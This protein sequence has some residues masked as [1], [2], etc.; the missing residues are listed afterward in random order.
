METPTN[1]ANK[2]KAEETPIVT[3]QAPQVILSTPFT[4]IF[5]STAMTTPGSIDPTTDIPRIIVSPNALPMEL[6]SDVLGTIHQMIASAIREL[7]AAEGPSTQLL[8]QEVKASAF[9]QGFLDEDFL[10]FLAKKP[11]T[12]FDDLLAL[13]AKYIN[14]EDAQV[15]KREGLGEKKKENKDEGPSKTQRSDFKDK[16]PAWQRVNTVYT[17]LAVPITQA[18]MAVEGKG[19]LS[20]PKSYKD[21]P[22]QPKSDKFRRFHNDYWHTTNECRHLK[23]ETERL[24]ENRYLQEY[25]CW[26][27]GRGTGPYQKYKTDIDENVKNPSL[28]SPVKGV[29]SPSITGNTEI[30]DPQKKS[31]IRMIVSSP[32]GGD[33]QRSRK[34]QV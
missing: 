33:L 13:A 26:E 32:S 31:V 18:L 4:P 27:K 12:K 1:V 28:E 25:V 3:S 15:S 23:N 10:K 8:T 2:Q 21:G 17:P 29:P 16:K 14:M 11:T 6:S 34:A 9:A 30:N 19:L 20:R 24:I 7:N 22:Q 5:G